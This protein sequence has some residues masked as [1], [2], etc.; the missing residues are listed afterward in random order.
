[1]LAQLEYCPSTDEDADT[2]RQI[3]SD[4]APLAGVTCLLRRAHSGDRFASDELFPLV[5]DELRAIA[6][7]SLA[8]ES[9]GHTLQPTALVHEAYLR[10]ARPD[11]VSWEN[12]GHFFGA[13]ARAIRR[14]LIDHAR[15]KLRDK[16]GAGAKKI[17]LDDAGDL[18]DMDD[19]EL[20]GLDDALKRLAEMDPFKSS[21]VELRFFGGL[22]MD[23]VS[24]TLDAS[25]STVAREWRFARAWLYREMTA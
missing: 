13:A 25:P 19:R 4:G 22:T 20:I 15:T 3:G 11:E 9:A 16:R 21:I 10:L 6:Q 7:R 2:D 1:M 17:G 14:I 18:A 24:M 12:R 8:G 23:E 5:Y